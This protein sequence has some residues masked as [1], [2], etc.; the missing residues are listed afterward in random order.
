MQYS[1][2]RPKSKLK[3]TSEDFRFDD[4]GS[5]VA[6]SQTT[7]EFVDIYKLPTALSAI[8][9]DTYCQT[10]FSAE[11]CST[12]QRKRIN[13]DNTDLLQNFSSDM[14]CRSDD[15]Q[16]KYKTEIC[17]N[18]E[19]RGFCQWGDMVGLAVLFRSR[20]PRAP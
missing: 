14:L 2:K 7:D 13:S 19:F 8:E 5:T 15:Y 10:L 20:C 6:L 18:F 9:G 3:P 11:N 1:E 16:R 12:P 17:K 4:S